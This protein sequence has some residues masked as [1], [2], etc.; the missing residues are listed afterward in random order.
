MSF[1]FLDDQ[2]SGEQ[3]VFRN[4]KRIISAQ[5]REDIPKAFAEIDAAIADGYWLAGALSYE[6]GH[7][8]EAKFQSPKK[9]PL[10]HLGVF[11]APDKHPPASFLYTRK[12]PGIKFAPL[13]TEDEYLSRFTKVQSYLESGDCYQVNLTFPMHAT[14]DVSPTQLYAAYR[15]QQPGRYGA[16]I[17]CLLYT[18][19][20]PRDRQ[21][22]RMPSS[23]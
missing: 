3:F 23:A 21:K 12:K 5:T 1:V 13:W 2:G 20:S 14:S 8:L 16:V 6:L 18:S 7:A 11:D 9:A 4:P 10:I 19:P 15:R 22:S 17:A